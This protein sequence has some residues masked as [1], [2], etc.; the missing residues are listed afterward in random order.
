MLL[1]DVSASFALEI[2]RR[3]SLFISNP[4]G[5]TVLRLIC[6]AVLRV[7]GNVTK[8]QDVYVTFIL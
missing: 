1:L 2:V 3:S 4:N 5:R 6:K 8:A 7:A